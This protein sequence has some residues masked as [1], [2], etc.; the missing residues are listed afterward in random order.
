MKLTVHLQGDRAVLDGED[1][2]GLSFVLREA[3]KPDERG[4]RAETKL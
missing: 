1:G 4:D 2:A 3:W